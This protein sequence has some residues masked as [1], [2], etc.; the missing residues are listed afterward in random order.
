MKKIIYKLRAIFKG[1]WKGM[2]N[3]IKY[4]HKK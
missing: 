4:V 3:T 1:N 2:F